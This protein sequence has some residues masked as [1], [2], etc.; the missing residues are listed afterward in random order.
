MKGRKN[1]RLAI[2]RRADQGS[3]RSWQR[4]EKTTPI[5]KV[6]ATSDVRDTGK[7]TRLP[8]TFLKLVWLSHTDPKIAGGCNDDF[9]SPL[10]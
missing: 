1:G 7:P 4:F 8:E 6:V 10:P 3:I 5:S 2:T 9:S